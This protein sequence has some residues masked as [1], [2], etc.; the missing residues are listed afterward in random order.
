MRVQWVYASNAMRQDP[1]ANVFKLVHDWLS[2]CKHR[3]LLVLDN[4]EDTRFLVDR[5][6]ANLKVGTL[7]LRECLPQCECGSILVT[8]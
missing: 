3:W 7:L 5:L 4:V 6:A 2:E 8:M 1:Q